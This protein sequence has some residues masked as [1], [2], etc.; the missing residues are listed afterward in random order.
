VPLC[1]VD[2]EAV[3]LEC[4]RGILDQLQAGQITA[5]EADRACP[6]GDALPAGGVR[7]KVD[8]EDLWRNP[9][10]LRLWAA[11][12]ISVFGSQFTALAVPIIAAV[13]LGATPAQMGL[14]SAIGTAPF[15]LFAVAG[16]W[17]DRLPRRRILVVADLGRAVV[18]VTIPLLAFA[19]RLEILH[20]YLVG[21]VTSLLT[22]LFDV[23]DQ[24]FLPSLVPREHLVEANSRLETTRSLA[25][26]MGPGVAGLL[27]QA[28]SAPV[29]V[30]LDA[31][32]FAISA[33]LIGCIRR[34]SCP[35]P[36]AG[37]KS[38]TT[39]L[40]EGV[41]FVLGNPYLRAI[42]LCTGSFN[43]V[44]S[45][46]DALLVLF[47]TRELGLLPASLGLAFSVANV[48]G[49]GGALLARRFAAMLGLGR[50]I[51]F[52]ALSSG[53]WLLPVAA[54]TR[55][56]AFLLLVVGGML[57]GL[58]NSVYNINQ[59]S[60]RQAI[61]PLYLQ[62]RVNGTMRFLVWGTM[63]L[64]GLVGG[65]LGEMLGLRFALTVLAAL[66]VLPFLWVALS[67]V[68]ELRA[69]PATEG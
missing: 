52:G 3:R 66:E 33:G 7:V 68:R 56:T 20:L 12:A 48:A 26:L 29:T 31:V 15:L 40:R 47:A 37:K 17:V 41:A 25:R 10:F 44:S 9:D 58:G 18:L 67:P 8:G 45:A 39:E 27:I 19:G 46:A 13:L 50:A 6:A 30:L 51:L 64:G 62:G 5:E 4:R 28:L 54:A 69:I 59:V 57:A 32:S 63:P 34:T 60:L 61:T 24:A 36:R 35:H 38:V 2:L 49:V 22:V 16:V 11:Q 55:Q 53:L 21:A 23:A 42:A 43:L 1:G 65:V 14:L